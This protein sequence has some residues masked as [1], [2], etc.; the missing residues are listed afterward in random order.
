[1]ARKADVA[2]RPRGRVAHGPREGQVARGWRR[3]MAGGHASPR[4][5]QCGAPRDEGGWQVKG[6]R[7]SG[8]SLGVWGGNA[9]ALSRPS[10]Y[11]YVF[12]FFIPCGTMF[13]RN[14]S[15]AGDVAPSPASDLI[16]RR[17]S[18]GPKTMRSQSKHVR[19]RRFK[20]VR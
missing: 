13:P 18:C 14:L 9:N 10:F 16:A 7:V 4:E 20:S 15:F 1:M 3:H 8:P 6:P 17:R 2:L 11:T 12:P 5:R 19:Q